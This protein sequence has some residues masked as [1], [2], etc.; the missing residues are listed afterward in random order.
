MKLWFAVLTI[1]N[2]TINDY[3][4]V[5]VILVKKLQSCLAPNTFK[6]HCKAAQIFFQLKVFWKLYKYI[7][8]L[9]G[10]HLVSSTHPKSVRDKVQSCVFLWYNCCC[11]ARKEMEGAPGDP[12]FSYFVYIQIFSYHTIS[13]RAFA[14]K[15]M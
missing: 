13:Y 4:K 8:H 10:Y 3:K 7:Y 9:N 2:F 6:I 14:M 11:S 1:K 12:F 15:N 5:T